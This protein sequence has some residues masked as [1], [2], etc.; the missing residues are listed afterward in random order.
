MNSQL[1]N[2]NYSSESDV[3]IKQENEIKN[4]IELIKNMINALFGKV[5]IS[6]INNGKDEKTGNK[7]I[8]IIITSTKNQKKT[9][10]KK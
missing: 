3:I 9:K 6:D 7:N 10:M 8:S 1:P 2:S 5:N 4:R